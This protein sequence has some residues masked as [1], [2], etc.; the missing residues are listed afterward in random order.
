MWTCAF[1]SKVLFVLY[2]LLI[3]VATIML[4][5]HGRAKK[6]AIFILV[7]SMIPVL[8]YWFSTLAHDKIT[9]GILMLCATGWFFVIISALVFSF[10]FETIEVF[11]G[12]RG[13][14]IGTTGWTLVGGCVLLLVGVK[15]IITKLRE[16]IS[17]GTC[18]IRSVH[19]R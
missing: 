2:L 19:V 6:L 18:P 7:L 5:D 15:I 14:R 11:L 12:A 16:H 10:Y 8:S 3:F 9:R 4:T 17:L 13:T 1:Y